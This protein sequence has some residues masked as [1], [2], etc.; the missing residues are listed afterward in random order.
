M[1]ENKASTH[2]IQTVGLTVD[3]VLVDKE[4]DDVGVGL[5]GGDVYVEAYAEQARVD[6]GVFGE[7]D[8]QSL[9]ARAAD[10]ERVLDVVTLGARAVEV[11]DLEGV[12]VDQFVRGAIR[13][14]VGGETGAVLVLQDARPAEVRVGVQDPDITA[15]GIEDEGDGLGR[16]SQSDL[17]VIAA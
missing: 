11:L 17:G 3:E 9:D 10:V 14:F 2:K 8:L 1:V 12:R 16:C 15:P 7:A 4:I 6:G 13:G 5:V